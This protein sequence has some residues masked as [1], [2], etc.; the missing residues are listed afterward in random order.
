[1]KVGVGIDLAEQGKASVGRGDEPVEVASGVEI[2]PLA[3]A[4][5]VMGWAPLQRYAWIPMDLMI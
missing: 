1:M 2:P 3:S 4:N 5:P